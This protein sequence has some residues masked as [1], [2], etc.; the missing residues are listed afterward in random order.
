M[1]ITPATT[2][3]TAILRPS[4]EGPLSGLQLEGN[5]WIENVPA[6]DCDLSLALQALDAVPSLN[7][8]AMPGLAALS[9]DA[10][11]SAVAAIAGY[12][13]R[14]GAFFIVD[15]PANW[16][17]VATVV[18]GVGELASIVGENGAIYW[19]PFKNGVAA[20]ESVASIYIA[21]DTELGVWKAPA[22]LS[23]VVHGEPA[24][25][26]NDNENGILNPLGVNALRTFPVYGT[27]VWGARTLAGADQL[28]SDWKYVSVR[29]LALFLESS[30]VQSLQS[31]IYLPNDA[32]LWYSVTVA[33]NG[34][35]TG[36]WR[37]GAFFGSTAKDA[38]F[39]RCDASTTT[40]EDIEQ[41]RLNV[42]IG[43]APARPAEFIVLTIR[44]AAA[45]AES[46][47]SEA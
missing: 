39:V 18:E 25:K 13:V 30:I 44:I 45:P 28:S 47:A 32:A 24:Y 14:R 29:R 7:L 16:T 19:P 15:P 27:V 38:F 3:T 21:T 17:T 10:Y 1:Q 43:F 26:L 40:A 36:L 4:A 8:V 31:V 9:G 5:L 41:G 12:C 42:E 11:A 34:F 37:E 33:V 22:G 23:A 46:V 6:E 2:T 20:S 35:L